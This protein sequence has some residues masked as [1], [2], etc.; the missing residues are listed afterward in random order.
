MSEMKSEMA[1]RA[2]EGVVIAEAPKRRDKCVCS[3]HQAQRN[4]PHFH[5]HQRLQAGLPPEPST[6]PKQEK[7]RKSVRK[8]KSP[9]Q[10]QT[11]EGEKI[12]PKKEIK[13]KK[14][15]KKNASQ[16]ILPQSTSQTENNTNSIEQHT[17]ALLGANG[18]NIPNKTIGVEKK[19]PEK[20][21][22]DQPKL[23]EN[24]NEYLKISLKL[25]E[26]EAEDRRQSVRLVIDGKAKE[27]TRLIISTDEIDASQANLEKSEV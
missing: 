20:T 5:H 11:Q 9:A 19:I 22:L 13:V 2:Q 18:Q 24:S 14:S 21:Q 12:K 7:G 17:L 1:T 15:K 6:P 26:K 23:H 16:I 3:N 8:K 4:H 10:N 27:M 25:K